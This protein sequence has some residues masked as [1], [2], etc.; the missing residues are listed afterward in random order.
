MATYFCQFSHLFQRMGFFA[1]P[2][3]SLKIPWFSLLKNN[4]KKK[5]KVLLWSKNV[6][7]IWP[8]FPQTIVLVLWHVSIYHL[9]LT[10]KFF[11]SSVAK[12]GFH[13]VLGAFFCSVSAYVVLSVWILWRA[14]MM[15]DQRWHHALREENKS[16]V[17]H[18]TMI[19]LKNM[20]T[21]TWHVCNI[22][23]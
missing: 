13:A 8:T 20:F 17:R 11:C 2:H 19:W 5:W 4:K 15:P 21:F 16:F 10:L 6:H 7:I 3:D 18:C 12:N 22:W 1:K 14:W 23:V 9:W